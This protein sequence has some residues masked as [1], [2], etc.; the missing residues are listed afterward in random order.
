MTGA[1]SVPGRPRDLGDGAL[2][3][4]TAQVSWYLVVGLLLALGAVPSLLLLAFLDR[5]SGN[6]L[7]VPLCLLPAM[8][9]LAAA[10]FALRE[11]G[12]PDAS[13]P[14]RAFGRGLRLSTRDVLALTAPALLVVGI[15]TTSV[16]HREAAGISAL[17]AGLL[18]LIG[19][20]VVLWMLEAV[21]LASLFSFRVRDVARLS[22]HYLTRR[23]L[24]TVGLLALLLVAAG[25]VWAVG[26]P[27][28]ALFGIVWAAFLLRTGRPVLDDVRRRFVA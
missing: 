19:V 21:L 18:A 11:L 15:I 9:F 7:L 8:P 17:Y 1:G 25:V 10:L 6:A 26:E 5:S 13:S 28:L 3:R 12:A 27:V 24:V 23:P 14:A 16:V 2:G 4:L 20:A 22:L